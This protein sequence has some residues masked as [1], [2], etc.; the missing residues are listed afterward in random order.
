MT[1]LWEEDRVKGTTEALTLLPPSSWGSFGA[2]GGG[3]ALSLCF[4]KWPGS[5]IPSLLV[6]EGLVPLSSSLEVEEQRQGTESR[7]VRAWSPQKPLAPT[8]LLPRGLGAHRS[9]SSKP[10]TG[11]GPEPR[12]PFL[13]V[14]RLP[15]C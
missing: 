6:P 12:L 13:P 3:A 4:P 9:H 7:K 1:A 5:P 2:R 10:A 11:L 14:C 8:P 15:M